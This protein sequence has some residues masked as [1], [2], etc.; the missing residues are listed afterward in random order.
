MYTSELK[1]TVFAKTRRYNSAL[2]AALTATM[3][4]KGIPQPDQAIEGNL[5]L[6]HKYVALRKGSG[7]DELHMYDLY[8]PMVHDEQQTIPRKPRPLWCRKAWRPWA[9]LTLMTSSKRSPMVGLTGWRIGKT[10]G[11]LVGD[12]WVHPYVLMNY[13]DNLDNM[14]TRPRTW[15]RD[16]L[17]LLRQKPALCQ[18]PVQHLCGGSGFN[19]E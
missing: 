16:A 11:L 15:A 19:G 9:P 10:V 17:V 18:R 8:V 14:F 13:Q 1:Q 4:S 5:E 6:L 7:V 3:S 12:I 2:E